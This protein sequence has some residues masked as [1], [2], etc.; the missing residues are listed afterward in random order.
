VYRA[1]EAE[2]AS[3]LTRSKRLLAA[4]PERL[5]RLTPVFSSDALVIFMAARL[6]KGP[7]LFSSPGGTASHTPTVA[8][9]RST[10]AGSSALFVSL[11][12]NIRSVAILFNLFDRAQV[13]T[14]PGKKN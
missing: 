9:G 5:R 8:A 2:A 11:S 14:N 12:F 1:W 3:K 13:L 7:G 10:C 6:K 4:T